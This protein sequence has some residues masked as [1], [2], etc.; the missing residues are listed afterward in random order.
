LP[1]VPPFDDLELKLAHLQDIQFQLADARFA[2]LGPQ[3]IFHGRTEEHERTYEAGIRA[4]DGRRYE[5]ALE[6]FSQTAMTAG[7]RTDA[8]LFWKAYALHRLGRR[9]E[10]LASLAELRK[11]HASSRWIG[12]AQALETEIKQ[13]SGTSGAQLDAAEDF[14]VLAL[15]GLMQTDPEKAAPLVEQT[16]KGSPYRKLQEVALQAIARNDSRRNRELLEQVARGKMGNPDLQLRAIRYLGNRRTD[17]RELLREIYASS[18]DGLVKH[19]ALRALGTT[20]DTEHL[21]R[22]VRSE[23]DPELRIDALSVLANSAS[24]AELWPLYQGETSVEAKELI[25]RRLKDLG[26]TERLLEVAKTEKEPKLRQYAIRALGAVT[27]GD[28]LSAL[29]TTETD[30]TVKRTIVDALYSHKN[31][32][33][34]VALARNEKDPQMRREIVTRLSRMNSKEALDY[35]TELLK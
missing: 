27:T 15:S 18:T 7:S 4:L 2:K 28:A 9:D 35:L 14:K 30:H 11:S 8:A 5:R 1:A 34:L 33:V 17:N 13:T 20:D 6:A 12:D 29:Y 26:V 23:K 32:K 19:A 31:G 24:S 3:A 22:I 16:L 25:L 21:L 10:A